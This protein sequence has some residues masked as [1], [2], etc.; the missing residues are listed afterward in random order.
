[1]LAHRPLFS[2]GA[3]LML[4]ASFVARAGEGSLSL[5]EAQE[6]AAARSKQVEAST[7]AVSA[8]REMQVAAA[9]RP[10]PVAT[11]GVQNLPINGADQFSLQR[12]FMTMQSVGLMQEITRP[13]KLHARS[14]RAGDAEQLAETERARAFAAVRRDTALA[15]LGRY[16]AEA[17]AHLVAEEAE[18]ARR[19]VTASEAAYRGG[20]GL[21][22]DVLAVRGVAAQLED[23]VSDAERQVRSAKSALARFIGDASERQLSDAPSMDAVLVHTHGLEAEL[24]QHPQIL[25]LERREALA[26]ADAEVA[27]ADR[28]PDWS[29]ELMY[30]KRGIGYSDMVTL[31]FSVPLEIDRA[32]RQNRELAAKLAE[33]SQAR[34]ERED[35]LREHVA[36]F[37]SMLEEW[38]SAR[39]RRERYGTSIIPLAADRSQAAAAA[40]RGGKASLSDLLLARRDEIDAR[41]KALQLEASAARLW[42]ELTF[43]DVPPGT[44]FIPS[45]DLP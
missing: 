25:A 17:T 24:A 32:H 8:A 18:A 42:A 12:D 16:F 1:M 30:S 4:G 22:A 43:N 5:A 14:V 15:W 37:R 41:L 20:R 38:T 10:D 3:A 44:R 7:Y 23:M 40:Y 27:R 31:E 26:R 13:S 39:D 11:F 33:A 34:A 28:R 35:M 36:E 21:A 45:G 6:L 2:M 19:E 9:Q 29:V